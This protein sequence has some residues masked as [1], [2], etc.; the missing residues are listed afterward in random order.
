VQSA[1]GGV[2]HYLANN[3]SRV[4]RYVEAEFLPIDNNPAERSVKPFVIERKAWLYSD[5]SHGAAAS[6]HL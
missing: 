1:L 5:T 6:A 4:G 2:V 3:W